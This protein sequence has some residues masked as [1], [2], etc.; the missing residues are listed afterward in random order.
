[1]GPVGRW[2]KSIHSDQSHLAMLRIYDGNNYYRRELENDWTGL[3][4]RR[5][6]TR[7]QAITDPVIWVWD[8]FQSNQRRRD[9][10][11]GYKL[12]RVKPGGDIF[13]GFKF[14]Q[15]VLAHS[16]VIQ[17]EVPYYEADDVV[18]TLV[19]KFA[20]TTPV[21]V[22]SADFDF[23]QL[24]AEFP[25]RVFCGCTPKST[26]VVVKPEH[27]RLYKVTVGDPSDN[28]PG[29]PGF[30]TVSWTKNDPIKLSKAIHRW[31]SNGAYDEHHDLHL[32]ARSIN[33]LRDNIPTLIDFWSIIGF[34]D[35]PSDVIEQHTQ[36]GDRNSVAADAL[37]REFLN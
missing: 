30:G 33:W 17:I 25:S 15:Q 34:Y 2:F 24:S 26:D 32:Y 14:L 23:L 16:N 22:Y 11:P 8:G 3:T 9:I 29:I 21:S 31:M 19:R 37:L 5:V 18:A 36:V 20:P 10:Y 6:Y 4:P 7:M 28:I 12:R 13:E 1:M 35:V 27:V